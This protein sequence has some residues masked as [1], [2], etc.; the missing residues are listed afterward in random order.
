MVRREEA[1]ERGAQLQEKLRRI[2]QH[3]DFL[4]ESE[5]P[6]FSQR[7]LHNVIRR[8]GWEVDAANEKQKMRNYLLSIDGN[9]AEPAERRDKARMLMERIDAETDMNKRVSSPVPSKQKQGY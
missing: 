9:M 3:A 2:Q 1:I 8:G 7:A 4:L 6:W 5:R